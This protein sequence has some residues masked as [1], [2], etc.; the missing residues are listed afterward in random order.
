[1]QKRIFMGL[2]ASAAL[3]AAALAAGNPADYNG[4]GRISKEEF[5]N[6]TA[7][8]AFEA[9]KNSNGAI[10]ADEI[11]FS[12]DQRK[13]LD[14]DGDGKVSVEEFQAGNMSGFGQADKNGDGFL[15]ANEMKGG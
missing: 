3:G 13:A 2:F 1:M 4:D 9:D 8:V 10:D 5:R 6:Q 11:K 15:D 12:D 7:R 14:A